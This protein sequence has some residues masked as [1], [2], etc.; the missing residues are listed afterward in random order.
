MGLV[1]GYF[2]KRIVTEKVTT[3]LSPT[4]E[5]AFSQF[6]KFLDDNG[7]LRGDIRWYE[8]YAEEHRVVWSWW[9]TPE[10]LPTD[11]WQ[12]VDP[13]APW[14]KQL[15]AYSKMDVPM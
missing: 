11:S 9:N 3:T 2:S 12:S 6:N 15:W 7:Y 5:E 14:T 4:H 8:F 1:T 13:S 10:N